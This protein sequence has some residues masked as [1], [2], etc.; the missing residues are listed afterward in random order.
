MAKIENYKHLP[1]KNCVTTAIRNILNFYG[2]RFSE[3]MIFGLAEGYGF[4]FEIISALENPYLGGTG[5]KLLESFCRNVGLTYEIKE[6]DSDEEALA[7]LREYIDRQIP[8]ILQVDLKYL[9][10]FESKTHFAAH[11]VVACGY[12]SKRVHLSDTGFKDIQTCTTEHL[13]KA[14]SSDYPP[15]RT[16]RRRF[17]IKR[18]EQ[19][20]FIEEMVTK[21]LYNLREKFRRRQSGYDLEKIPELKEHLSNYKDV[22]QLFVQI[23]KAGTGG[24][25][26]RKLFAAF[27]DQ[28]F[29]IYS[30]AIYE[31]AAELFTQS[32]QLWREIALAARNANIS[33]AAEKLDRIYRLEHE[34]IREFSRFEADDV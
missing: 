7:D 32:A 3:A 29:Q 33:G 24:G 5:H 11:R 2:Y 34:G 6:F 1:G 9:D 28:S 8:V 22:N 10:Y 18:P 19:K 17:V 20:P 12:D 13:I 26:S 23:E 30:R 16:G 25:L 15:F 14:R 21:A 31:R 27:L 4:Q